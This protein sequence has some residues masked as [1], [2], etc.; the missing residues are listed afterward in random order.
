M[1][2]LRKLYMIFL[3][4]LHGSGISKLKGSSRHV[5]IYYV[6]SLKYIKGRLACNLES[7]KASD[8]AHS[9]AKQIEEESLKH[10]ENISSYP[11]F[12]FINSFT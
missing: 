12:F 4:P 1:L 9:C 8:S 7:N 6:V 5:I 11:V 2:A 10:G 3:H